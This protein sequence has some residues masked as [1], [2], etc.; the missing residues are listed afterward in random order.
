MVTKP[1]KK[2]DQELFALIEQKIKERNYLF[3]KHAK[4]RQQ[5]RN[6]SELDVLN[7]LEGKSGYDRKRNKSKDSYESNYIH[8]KPQDWKY[9]IEGKDID[10]KKVR[11]ILTFTDDLMPIITVINLSEEEMP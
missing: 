10:E 3:V 7:I 6:I 1:S 11:I 8:E 9:C 2:T 4:E 5:Q